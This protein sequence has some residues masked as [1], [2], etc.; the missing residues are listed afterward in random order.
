MSYF[1]FILLQRGIPNNAVRLNFVQKQ[2]VFVVIFWLWIFGCGILTLDSLLW[3]PTC[4]LLTEIPDCGPEAAGTR[5][6]I[7]VC[8]LL[9]AESWLRILG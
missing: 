4:D 3:I 7:H 6:V 5:L 2:L 9:A 8:G 1:I